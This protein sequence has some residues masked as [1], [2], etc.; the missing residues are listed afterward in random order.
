MCYHAACVK[1]GGLSD[2]SRSHSENI[3]FDRNL[4]STPVTERR[5]K[6]TGGS[7][8]CHKAVLYLK[9]EWSPPAGLESTPGPETKAIAPQTF[10]PLTKDEEA[11]KAVG[12]TSKLFVRERK[13]WKG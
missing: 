11:L 2:M 6:S 5:Y 9:I 10:G 13:G 7:W 8:P 4:S 1:L 3:G 12:D